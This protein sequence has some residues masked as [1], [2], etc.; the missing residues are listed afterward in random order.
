MLI[1][2]KLIVR[3]SV[4]IVLLGTLSAC[5]STGSRDGA[6]SV[7][8]IDLSKIPNA[9]PKTETL[10]RYG[11]PSSYTVRG[12][13]YQ[14]RNS[15]E[16]YV[17]R[18]KASWYGTKFQG[19]RTSSG[20]P[21]DMYQMTAAHKTLPLP[22]Y[23][24][25]E[26]L[27]NGKTVIV[28]VNDRGPFHAGRI[29]DL[30]YVAALKLDIVKTGTGNVEVRTIGSGPTSRQKMA[31]SGNGVVVN[32]SGTSDPMFV[33]VGS[34]SS[35]ENAQQMQTRLAQA[36]IESNIHKIVINARKHVYR[37]R[38]GPFSPHDDTGQ[39]FDDLK[40]IGVYDAR[41]LSGTSLGGISSTIL[42]NEE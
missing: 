15:S 20:I 29:I 33:Q 41:L 42:K 14:V 12:K 28:K 27:D 37:V 2:N 30:S 34:Y 31:S 8:N 6:P 24:E 10:S 38:V 19:R 35:K 25:V 21:Y 22:T 4:L 13:T 26:N 11:N 17:K 23:V 39:L 40:D 5:T 9:I 7:T 32:S 18:G 1:M 16:G 3:I 36:E